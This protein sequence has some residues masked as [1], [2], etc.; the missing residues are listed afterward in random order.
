MSTGSL[1]SLKEFFLVFVIVIVLRGCINVPSDLIS[2]VSSWGEAG[3][4]LSRVGSSGSRT[5]SSLQDSRQRSEILSQSFA[6]DDVMLD[7]VLRM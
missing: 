5:R 2:S 3:G 6:D 7:E 1:P 4:A